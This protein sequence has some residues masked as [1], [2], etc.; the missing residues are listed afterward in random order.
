MD[1]KHGKFYETYFRGVGN[2]FPDP[3][4]PEVEG[5]TGEGDP[6]RLVLGFQTLHQGLPEGVP[7]ARPSPLLPAGGEFLTMGQ[8]HLKGEGVAA[9]ADHAAVAFLKWDHR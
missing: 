8:H 7:R 1:K 2:N 3:A 5:Q 6:I 4:F 9:A